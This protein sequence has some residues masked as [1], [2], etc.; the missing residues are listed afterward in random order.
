MNFPLLMSDWTQF[1]ND[2]ETSDITCGPFC[3]YKGNLSQ[4]VHVEKSLV[5]TQM[6]GITLIGSKKKS[7]IYNFYVL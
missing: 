5:F 1:L 6:L 7:N 2:P 4:K 3:K